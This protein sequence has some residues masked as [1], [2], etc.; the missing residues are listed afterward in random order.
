MH[1]KIAPDNKNTHRHC[2]NHGF[3]HISMPDLMILTCTCY[4]AVRQDKFYATM[5]DVETWW[6]VIKYGFGDE[7]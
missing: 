1:R 3:E 2:R 7:N 5:Q 4:T 6:D